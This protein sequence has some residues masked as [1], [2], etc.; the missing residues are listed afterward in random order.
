MLLQTSNCLALHVSE[1]LTTQCFLCAGH[2]PWF[3][4]SSL[5]AA[6]R[7]T[8]RY[9]GP[10]PVLRWG[11][12]CII[13]SSWSVEEW[14]NKLSVNLLYLIHGTEQSP[15]ILADAALTMKVADFGLSKTRQYL[16]EVLCVCVVG[17]LCSVVASGAVFLAN[18]N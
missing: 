13:R 18:T 8:S 7:S 2:C 11:F 6:S 17:V 9:Q 12:V 1:A 15:N 14:L 10:H 5:A 16:Q 4:L 3:V